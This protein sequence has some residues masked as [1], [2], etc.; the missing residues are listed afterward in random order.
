MIRVADLKS[1]ASRLARV[2]EEARA[3]D[4]DLVRVVDYMKPGVEEIAAILPRRAGEWLM[5]KDQAGSWFTRLQ[6]SLQVRSSSLW[7]HLLLRALARLRPMRRAS[8][9]FAQEEDAIEAW[10]AAMRQALSRSPEY[11]RQLAALP[12]VLKGYG[13]T[14]RRGRHN[15]ARLWAAHV[16]PVLGPDGEADLAAAARQLEQ[17]LAATLADPEGRLNQ[18]AATLPRAE[19]VT[20]PI[21]WMQRP[22]GQA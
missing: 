18:A 12:Q 10:T 20:R 1:R 9:R 22:G 13:E 19:P 3:S 8:L 5:R 2:R 15:Y 7:G 6:P 11:A 21:Q 16:A 4:A 14:Y 17:G